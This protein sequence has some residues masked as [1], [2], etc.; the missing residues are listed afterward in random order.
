MKNIFYMAEN[1]RLKNVIFWLISQE[2][3]ESQEDF[4]TKLG[5]NPS[6]LSQIVT[7]VKPLSKKFAEKIVEFCNKINTDY[8]FGKGEMLKSD[9]ESPEIQFYDPENAPAGRKL[10]PFYDDVSS[11][12]GIN[13]QIANMDGVSEPAEYIDPGDWFKNATSAI[14]NYGDSMSEYPPGC[15]LVLKEVYDRRLIIP[16]KD[17]VIET[18]EYRITKRAHI[19]NSDCLHV[20]STNDEKYEDGALIHPPFNI[21]W[22]CITKISEVLAHIVKKGGGTEVL[23]SIPKK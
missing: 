13:E 8:L 22:E 5:Y 16:G 10:I 6:F 18:S 23:F 1:K 15:I 12:G 4:A 2:I 9:I 7:G 11:R 17:Y 20:R 21:L 14:R 3:V 19:N